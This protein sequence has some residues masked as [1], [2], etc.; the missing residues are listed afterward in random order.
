MQ[1]ISN[2]KQEDIFI[3]IMHIILQSNLPNEY[4]TFII[5]VLIFLTFLFLISEKLFL[6]K[7]G[8]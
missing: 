5:L 4:K 7:R 3:V 8:E 6:T 2:L 1:A